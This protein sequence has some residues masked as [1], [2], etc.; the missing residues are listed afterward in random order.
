[1]FSIL[2]FVKLEKEKK[3]THSA[4]NLAYRL[5]SVNNSYYFYKPIPSAVLCYD[6]VSS[7]LNG[8]QE[9]IKTI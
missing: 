5:H 8:R 6:E 7:T 4:Q 2:E 9:M 1:M 3:K